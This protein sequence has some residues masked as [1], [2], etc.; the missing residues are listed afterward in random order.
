MERQRETARKKGEKRT[1]GAGDGRK[2][3]TRKKKRKDKGMHTRVTER[4]RDIKT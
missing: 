2:E 3:K 4:Q 1:S